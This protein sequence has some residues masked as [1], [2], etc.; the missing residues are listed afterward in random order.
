MPSRFEAEAFLTVSAGI[1]DRETVTVN[2][3]SAG[4]G[5]NMLQL[6]NQSVIYLGGLPNDPTV[7]SNTYK[8]FPTPLTTIIY[9]EYYLIKRVI[10]FL[11]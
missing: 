4:G 7:I 5:I 1:N 3:S 10:F 2:G 9:V 11:F 8:Y 6:T